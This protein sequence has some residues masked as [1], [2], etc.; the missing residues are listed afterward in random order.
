VGES[1]SSVSA[2][3]PLNAI[4]TAMP[5]AEKG[6]TAFVPAMIVIAVL[7]TLVFRKTR[8]EKQ[9]SRS[10]TARVNPWLR[11][12]FKNQWVGI[13]SAIIALGTFY[14]SN[15]WKREDLVVYFRFNPEEL[16]MPRLNLI[17]IFSNAGK[18]S[19]FI[20]DVGIEEVVYHSNAYSNTEPD[21]DICKK[22]LLWD[23]T[24]SK[25]TVVSFPQGWLVALYH[26]KSAFV[27]NNQSLF[28]STNVEAGA[29]LGISTVYDLRTIDWNKFNVALFCPVLRFYNSAG[30]PSSAICDGYQIDTLPSKSGVSGSRTTPAGLARLLPTSGSNC[31]IDPF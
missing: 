27:S 19:I 1:G 13:V 23:F 7:V 30:K 5:L 16:S 17:Y 22:V 18:T 14:L 12:L 29:Q 21:M 8:T 11:E 25:P 2:S 20:E 3:S 4:W 10:R 9:Y 26:P 31:H 28:S 24:S 15:F 6:A